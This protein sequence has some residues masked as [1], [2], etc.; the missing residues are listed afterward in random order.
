MIYRSIL[1][2]TRLFVIAFLKRF[3]YVGD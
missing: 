1:L 2:L 3:F